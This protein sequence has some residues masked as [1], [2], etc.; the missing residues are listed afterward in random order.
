MGAVIIYDDV[1]I[2]KLIFYVSHALKDAEISYLNIS[3]L[4]LGLL[5]AT[6][7]LILYFLGR[8]IEVITDQPLKKVLYKPEVL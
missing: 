7:N 5:T 4:A 3:K 6:R 1:G 8:T 2:Q